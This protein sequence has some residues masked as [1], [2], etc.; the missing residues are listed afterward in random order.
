MKK[1]SLAILAFSGLFAASAAL[2]AAPVPSAVTI[3]QQGITTSS[4]GVQITT[5]AQSGLMMGRPAGSPQQGL[6]GWTGPGMMRGA[7]RQG[8]TQERSLQTER[9]RG[10][11]PFGM[12][13][14]GAL[15]GGITLLLVWSVLIS[16][17]MAL[18]QWTKLMKAQK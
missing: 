6:S 5:P 11:R 18:C 1:T 3:D 17:T 13:I 4:Q 12:M 15:V 7:A 2:A 14:A 9:Q 10:S 16:A 8:F